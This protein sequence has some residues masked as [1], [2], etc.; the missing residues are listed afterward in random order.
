MKKKNTKKKKK[1][2]HK[3][4]NRRNYKRVKKTYK[5]RYQKG[6]SLANYGDWRMTWKGGADQVLP[7]PAAAGAATTGDRIYV[8]NVIKISRRKTVGLGLTET[9]KELYIEKD[10]KIILKPLGSAW[11]RG[12]TIHELNAND[13]NM[14]MEKFGEDPQRGVT[15][16]LT[17]KS[18]SGGGATEETSEVNNYTISVNGMITGLAIVKALWYSGVTPE[19]NIEQVDDYYRM[20]SQLSS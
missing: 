17:K 7:S 20:I 1:S 4:Y 5:N 18:V 11:V 16:T 12:T 19:G 14:S 2:N 15:I 8:G 3:N 10:N 6:G 13:Y 9:E